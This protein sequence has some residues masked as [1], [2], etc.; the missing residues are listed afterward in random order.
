MSM[1][2]SKILF[3]DH[4]PF[5]GGAQLVLADH[6]AEL[7]RRYFAPYMAC[8][9]TIPE[10]IE[11]YR[12]AGA[13]VNII[14]MARLRGK[15]PLVLWHFIQSVRQLRSIIKQN[16]ID[17]V[18][19][20]TTRASYVASIAVIGLGV[21]LIWWVRDVLYP[22]LVF[23]LLKPI[24]ADIIYVSK[25]IKDAYNPGKPKGQ[26]VYVANTM[27]DRLGD[28][29]PS[30]VQQERRRWGIEDKD[31]VVGFMGRLVAEKGPEDLIRAIAKLVPEYPQLKALIVGTGRGQQNNVE[32]NLK[33]QAS[34]LGLE[35]SVIF[36]GYQSNEPF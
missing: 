21:P 3:V 20:N 32:E 10:L 18:V 27:H 9:D 34:D 35:D 11:R 6:I 22:K 16:Q 28:I 14:D 29:T 15:N 30:L 2:P 13:E 36:T 33:Q 7:D 8:T 19:S 5:I 12:S 17:L 31:I 4:T 1:Q 25:A 23:A 26:V 24:P